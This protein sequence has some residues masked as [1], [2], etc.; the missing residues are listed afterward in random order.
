MTDPVKTIRRL[1]NAAAGILLE[2]DQLEESIQPAPE[3]PRKKKRNKFE[4]QIEIND[5]VGSWRKP[6][7][8]KKKKK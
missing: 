2:L 1:R 3:T 7:S 5:S 6:E 8:L 4:D